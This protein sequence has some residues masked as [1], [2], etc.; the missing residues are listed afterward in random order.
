[1]P[2]YLVT[3]L[4]ITHVTMTMTIALITITANTPTIT[5][6]TYVAKS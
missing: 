3:Y 6:M 1:M 4:I 2:I 5:G